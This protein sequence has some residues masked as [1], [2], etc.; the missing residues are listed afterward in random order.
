LE[1]S[2]FFTIRVD[3]I[4]KPVDQG[5]KMGITV[6]CSLVSISPLPSDCSSSVDQQLCL[7]ILDDRLAPVEP[8]NEELDPKYW[9]DDYFTARDLIRDEDAVY[10]SLDVVQGS[11]VPWYLG[12]HTVSKMLNIV[13]VV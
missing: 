3:E 2:D 1:Q 12:A 6:I 4:L 7:K 13:L 9:F 11:L 5:S 10:R 8:P